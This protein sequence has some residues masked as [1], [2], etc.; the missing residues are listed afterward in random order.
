[1]V[2]K[3]AFTILLLLIIPQSA[4]AFDYMVA[5]SPAT[6][7]NLNKVGISSTN[8]NPTLQAEKQSFKQ[9]IQAMRDANKKTIVEK[10]NNGITNANTNRTNMMNNALTR[11]TA[12]LS[13]LSTKSATLKS[14]GKNTTALDSAITSAQTAVANA[15]AAVTVQKAKTYSANISDE[16]LLRS[17][18]AQMVLQF[19]S[20]ILSTYQLV[21]TAKQAVVAA[22]KE[23][24]KLQPVNNEA[25]I[26]ISN[27]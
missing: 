19:K 22:L 25:N 5:S 24:E 17:P 21:L 1:M 20:D 10:V 12:I 18:I 15:Q 6:V 16:T 14:Q 4:Y 23:Y 3:L 2:K 26:Q 11:F 13:D 8:L 9:Q 27:Q 7:R